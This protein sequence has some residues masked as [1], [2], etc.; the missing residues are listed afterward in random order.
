MF[1]PIAHSDWV[2]P[3]FLVIKSDGSIRICGHYKQIINRTSDCNKYPISGTED[4]F[5][6]LCRG[7]KF[8]KCD[9]SHAYQQS[10]LSAKSGF[11]LAVN[12]QRGF[13][14]P[15]ILQFDTFC[16]RNLLKGNR[17]ITEMGSFY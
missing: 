14:Q 9:L 10:I 17:Q 4:V 16:F 2:A 13:L 6:S 7:E 3:T 5:A 11:L 1:E 15:R 12:T 8:T